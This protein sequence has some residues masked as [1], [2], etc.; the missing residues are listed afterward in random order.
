MK[1]TRYGNLKTLNQRHY[2]KS[3]N[4]DDIKKIT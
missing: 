3:P 1:F 2:E 4:E